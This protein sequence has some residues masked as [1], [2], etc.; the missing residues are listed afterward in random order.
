MFIHTEIKIFLT[1]HSYMLIKVNKTF[2]TNNH[3]V[4]ALCLSLNDSRH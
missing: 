1:A 2:K 4:K 3:S